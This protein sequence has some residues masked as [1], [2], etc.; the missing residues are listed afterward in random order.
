M[1]KLCDLKVMIPNRC[2]YKILDFYIFYPNNLFL[3]LFGQNC[4]C[5]LLIL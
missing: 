3:L 1:V 4:H 2:N 5:F